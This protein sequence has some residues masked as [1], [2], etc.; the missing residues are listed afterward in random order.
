MEFVSLG[1]MVVTLRGVVVGDFP[2]QIAKMKTQVIQGYTMF[3]SWKFVQNMLKKVSL[4]SF[5]RERADQI[6][7]RLR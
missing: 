5:L 4:S 2:I 3:W 1:A 7:Q 6:Q